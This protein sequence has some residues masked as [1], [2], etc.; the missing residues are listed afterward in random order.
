MIKT[1]L[2][3]IKY[4]ISFLSMKKVRVDYGLGY[5]FNLTVSFSNG[6]YFISVQTGKERITGKV[7]VN[8]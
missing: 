4:L 3:D 6:I 2:V 5:E 8:H 1:H 7:V